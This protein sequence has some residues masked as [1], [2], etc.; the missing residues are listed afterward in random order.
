MAAQRLAV[1]SSDGV[2]ISVS[3]SGSGPA[4]LLIHGAL[5][6]ATL[7][8]FAVQAKLAEQFTVYAMD[9]RGRAPSGDGKEY[10][11]S[12]EAD[13]IVSVVEAIGE[14]VIIVAHSYGALATVEALPR[15]QQVTKLILYEP[16]GLVPE[17]AESDVVAKLERALA[18]DNREEIVTLFLREQVGAPPEVLA[19]FKTSPVWPI[20]LQISPTLPRE[21]RTVNAYVMQPE[22]LASCRIPAVMLAGSETRGRMREGADLLCRTMPDCRVVVLEGQ[23]HTAMMQAPELFIGKLLEAIRG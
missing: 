12:L 6:N 11:L 14:P 3:R 13:D 17:K 7:T 23:G 18:A 15:L 10:A 21:A 2:E 9:R 19:G 5:L 20:V 1:K 8:W 22:L 16:P 4:L